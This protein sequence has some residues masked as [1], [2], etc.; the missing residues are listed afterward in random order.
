MSSP[1]ATQRIGGRRDDEAT[2]SRIDAVW[3]GPWGVRFRVFVLPSLALGVPVYFAQKFLQHLGGTAL[4]WPR[5]WRETVAAFG[6][7]VG[8][9]MFNL[10]RWRSSAAS[11]ERARVRHR[12]R[13]ENA[14]PV[15]AREER[16]KQR[17]AL[18][19]YGVA[20]LFVSIYTFVRHECVHSWQPRDAWLELVG[21]SHGGAGGLG[22]IVEL[23]PH[24]AVASHPSSSDDDVHASAP[25][26]WRGTFLTPLWFTERTRVELDRRER[27]H[28][29]DG[30]LYCLAMD[31]EWL[32]DSLLGRD[33]HLV[34]LTVLAF[35]ALHLGILGCAAA[36]FG[37]A[38]TLGEEMAAEV[39]K[40]L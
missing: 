20:L 8:L 3:N 37:C 10:M 39:A 34:A 28:G 32:I 35:F 12:D 29:V 23:S 13:D 27:E 26:V 22:D 7:V 11:V 18:A 4:W 33:A 36:G 5:E 38:F 21:V 15:N 24:Q 6:T 25:P 14:A 40:V 2:S 9:S 31:E 17:V 19:W 30:V 1:V 16:G